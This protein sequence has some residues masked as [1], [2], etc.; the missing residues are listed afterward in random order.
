[1]KKTKYILSLLIVTCSVICVT[2]CK[3]DDNEPKLTDQQKATK[4][5]SEGSPWQVTSVILKP[6]DDIETDLLKSL[7]FTFGATGSGSSLEPGSFAASG[8]N[9]F[10]SAESN[11]TW[12]W[13]GNDATTISLT[14]ALAAEITDIEYNP[15]IDGA[16][17]ITLSFTRPTPGGRTNGLVGKYTVVL[18]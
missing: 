1:M 12:N 18:E 8:A 2:S 10:F 6:N 13:S 16:T 15:S 9:D 14:D 7:K 3:D 4:T 5:L 11:A 17:S